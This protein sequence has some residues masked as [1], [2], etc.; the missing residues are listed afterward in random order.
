[1]PPDIGPFRLREGQ[2]DSRLPLPPAL[3]QVLRQGRQR[4]RRADLDG[5][6]RSV[7]RER[8]PELPEEIFKSVLKKLIS[9]GLK[10]LEC[11]YSKYEFSKT[12]YLA[13]TA[14]ENNLLI[15]AGSDYHGRNKN[16]PLGKLNADF[17]NIS[18]ENITILENL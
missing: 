10:G 14:K 16:I 7:L 12:E 17:K 11:Y 18:K 8:E 3:L 2:A 9:Y 15:S 5:G 13:E 4:L 1:M 6:C